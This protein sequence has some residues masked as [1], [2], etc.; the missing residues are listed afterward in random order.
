MCSLFDWTMV[1]SALVNIGLEDALQKLSGPEVIRQLRQDL[2]FPGEPPKDFGGLYVY[3]LVKYGAGEGKGQPKADSVLAFFRQKEVHK[4]FQQ[5]FEDPKQDL[6]VFE[7]ATKTLLSWRKISEPLQGMNIDLP[8]EFLEF[9]EVFNKCLDQTR[10]PYEARVERKLD[11]LAERLSTSEKASESLLYRQMREWFTVLGYRFEAYEVKAKHFE[12]IINVPVRRGYDR[13][14]VQGVEGEA[15][16]THF[17]TLREH[18]IQQKTDE[19]WLVTTRRIAQSVRQAVNEKEH[20]HLFCYTLDELL[21]EQVD[22]SK[23][24]KWLE[25][26]FTSKGVGKAYVQLACTKDE[27]DPKTGKKITA[28]KYEDLDGY[29]SQW[30]DDPAKEHISI[31]GE[32]GMGKTWFTLHF[33]WTVLQK[34]LEAKEKGLARPRLPLVIPLRDYAKAVTVE[35]LFSEFIFRKHE[36]KLPGYSA[37]EQLCRMDKLLIIFDGFDEMA[38]RVDRQEMIDNYWRLTQVAKLSKKVILTSRTEHFPS[39]EESRRLFQAQLPSSMSA[40]TGEPPQ[41]E[42]LEIEKFTDAQI[43]QVLASHTQPKTIKKIMERDELRDLARRPLMINIILDALPE[44]D[45]GKPVD[46]SRVYLYAVKR[47]ME[48]D[49]KAERTFTS[50]ADKVYFLCELSWE[51]LSTDQMSLNYRAFPDRLRQL[52]GPSVQTQ[53]DLDHWHYDMMGQTMLIRN[54][55]GDYTPAHRSLLEFFVAYKLAAEMGALSEDFV[56]LARQQTYL[57]TDPAQNYT[58]SEYFQRKMSNQGCI[59]TKPPLANFVCEPMDRLTIA[60]WQKALPN[61]I[62]DLLDKMLVFEEVQKNLTKEVIKHI[63]ER[64]RRCP[65]CLSGETSTIFDEEKIGGLLKFE[66]EKNWLN[67]PKKL[68]I[69]TFSLVSNPLLSHAFGTYTTICNKC[70]CT[71]DKWKGQKH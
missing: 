46:L 18:V 64:D 26:E 55:D 65:M 35:S 51:M 38:A 3:A 70:Y 69:P 63:G 34:Y 53:K 56:A 29:I 66:E 6:T 30:L 25:E 16:I 47:K 4:A 19:G 57:T 49:I 36:M 62:W 60:V 14:L 45:A 39:T 31:L 61:V 71:I 8:Q 21:D 58:W 68:D 43:R 1:T 37:F 24:F 22:F 12:W 28:S 10:T 2:S 13:V 32:F 5:W 40:L 17:N 7:E 27:Y 52:F 41:F 33:G 23:Y 54:R 48:R 67:I 20:A 11:D 15:N 59:E 42:I 9:A 44:I 50:L